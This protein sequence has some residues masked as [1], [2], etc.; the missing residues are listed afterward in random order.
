MFRLGHKTERKEVE[1]AAE[2]AVV[3]HYKA[4]GFEEKRVAHLNCGYDYVLTKQPAVHHVEVK[5]TSLADSRFF[6]T[7]NENNGRDDPRWRLGL[8]TDALTKRPR[9]TIYDNRAFK[10]IFDIEP[11]V[12]IGRRIVE[13]KDD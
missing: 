10:K 1:E 2:S 13:P 5:G 4:K 12:F 3:A 8:V 6:L 9:V 7:R 11:Y